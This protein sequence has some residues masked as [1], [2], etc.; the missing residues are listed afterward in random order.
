ML[1]LV[2]HLCHHVSLNC[3]LPLVTPI[4]YKQDCWLCLAALQ[5]KPVKHGSTSSSPSI[6][7]RTSSASTCSTSGSANHSGALIS[8][9]SQF[10]SQSQTPASCG[11]KSSWQR[12]NTAGSSSQVLA[13]LA[14][15][16]W[17]PQ[18]RA[19]ASQDIGKPLLW[20]ADAYHYLVH[21][22][23]HRLVE[24]ICIRLCS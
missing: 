17:S 11:S 2:N 4:S 1:L 5:T 20:W 13:A 18:R 3:L 23:Q 14:P 22:E 12:L 7:H 15:D 6:Y 24:S 16:L 21:K 9:T 19:E 8:T 10:S